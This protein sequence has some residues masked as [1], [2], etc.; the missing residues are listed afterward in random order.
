MILF[1]TL[2]LHSLTLNATEPVVSPQAIPLAA[3]CR[4]SEDRV[5]VRLEVFYDFAGTDKETSDSDKQSRDPNKGDPDKKE[6]E[7]EPSHKSPSQ[8]SLVSKQIQEPVPKNIYIAVYESAPLYSRTLLITE[9]NLVVVTKKPLLVKSRLTTPDF[10]IDMTNEK[11][12]FS[13][14]YTIHISDLEQE[15]P[16]KCDY[17]H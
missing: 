17:R 1:L 16:I 2:L 12:E 13:G 9:K 4:G 10:Q 8:A 7:V 3:S 15:I 11:S 6:T 5:S 14:L